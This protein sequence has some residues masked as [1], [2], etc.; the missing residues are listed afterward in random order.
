MMN[1]KNKQ[2]LERI[3]S[4][5]SAANEN[6]QLPESLSKNSIVKLAEKSSVSKNPVC[7]DGNRKIMPLYRTTALV[8]SLAVVVGC[9]LGI[10]VYKESRMNIAGNDIIVGEIRNARNYDEIKQIFLGQANKSAPPVSSR[11]PSPAVSSVPETTTDVPTCA[12]QEE[13]SSAPI[14]VQSLPEIGSFEYDGSF[15]V[16]SD[17][18]YLYMAS[19]SSGIIPGREA[20]RVVIMRAYPVDSMQIVSTVDLPVGSEATAENNI[21]GLRLTADKLI[22]V[23]NRVLNPASADKQTKTVT[24]LY[25]I[26]DK[27]AP[28]LERELVQD[29]NYVDL[30]VSAGKLYTVTNYSVLVDVE[31][32]PAADSLVPSYSDNGVLRL[33]SAEQI[34]CGVTNPKSSYLVITTANIADASAPPIARAILGCDSKIYFSESTFVATRRFMETSAGRSPEQYTELYCFS[35][36][37]NGIEFRGSNVVEGVSTD[38]ISVDDFDGSIKIAAKDGVGKSIGESVYIFSDKMEKISRY[39]RVQ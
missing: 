26:A 34:Y 12:T 17:G 7:L 20:P 9:V 18:E 16:K 3:R 31:N 38:L 4:E 11:T 25:S 13:S 36:T 32:D 37:D 22:V 5:M 27:S 1:R 24:Y 30:L 39:S 21:I 2:T 6:L 14:S 29:G 33:L 15:L 19:K 10:S 23:V 8:A 28:V 35:I